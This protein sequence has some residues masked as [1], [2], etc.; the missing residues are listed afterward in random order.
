M[1]DLYFTSKAKGCY[2][3]T[4]MFRI[5][6][7]DNSLFSFHYMVSHIFDNDQGVTFSSFET[8]FKYYKKKLK[9]EILFNIN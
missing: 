2:L 5:P 3:C 6:K 7:R 8:F 9:L 1:E 4:E